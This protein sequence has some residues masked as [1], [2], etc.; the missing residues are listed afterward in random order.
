MAL[1]IRRVGE[2]ADGSVTNVKLADNAVDLDS[3]KVT[4]QL[5]TEKLADGAVIEDKLAVLS[6]STG[7]LK[8]QAVSLAKAQ[9]ALKIHHFVGDETED[10]VVGITEVD[11][12]IF[13]FPKASSNNKG[14]SPTRLHVN[15]ELKTSAAAYQGTLKVYVDGEGTPRITLNTI[16][17]TYEMVEGDADITDLSPGKHTVT[18]KLYSAD[19]LGTVYNDL[20]EVFLEK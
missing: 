10:S 16:S 7:K 8:D 9:Q 4:G 2:V 20:I 1:Y 18:T 6:V 11:S 12:K 5:P 13:K 14:I 15:A 19:A 3:D 17:E